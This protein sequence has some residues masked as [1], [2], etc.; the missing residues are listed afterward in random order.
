MRDLFLLATDPAGH[1]PRSAPSSN[2]NGSNG[3][4]GRHDAASQVVGP[5]LRR[6]AL[7]ME[8]DLFAD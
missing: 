2:V 5:L 3:L 8:T 4:H 7:R 1:A 6:D